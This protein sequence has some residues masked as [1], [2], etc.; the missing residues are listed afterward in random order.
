MSDHIDNEFK[1]YSARTCISGPAVNKMLTLNYTSLLPI[2][3][4]AQTNVGK[5]E[6]TTLYNINNAYIHSVTEKERK[7]FI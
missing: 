7:N 3:Y 6:K 2:N 5:I 4:C 1:L